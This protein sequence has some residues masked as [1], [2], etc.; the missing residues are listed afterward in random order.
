MTSCTECS[1]IIHTQHETIKLKELKQERR[2]TGEEEDVELCQ[3]E[4][5]KFNVESVESN[6]A[7]T[8]IRESDSCGSCVLF[9]YR[10]QK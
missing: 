1:N 8:R 5:L 9:G 6:N 2:R 7:T 10:P 4:T 3:L